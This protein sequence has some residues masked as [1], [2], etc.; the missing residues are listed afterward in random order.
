MN[1][2]VAPH[3]RH[4]LEACKFRL[5]SQKKKN[6]GMEVKICE[7]PTQMLSRRV[8]LLGVDEVLAPLNLKL[9]ISFRNLQFQ[10]GS[11]FVK[12]ACLQHGSLS[13][14]RTTR[15]GTKNHRDV[16]PEEILRGILN[17]I[18]IFYDHCSFL[19]FCNFKSSLTLMFVCSLTVHEHYEQ[20]I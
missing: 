13:W 18:M 5:F 11:K 19:F 10:W 20:N 1:C 6:I 14:V 15:D 8:D 4:S 16:L 17:I 2:F 9:Q 7:M 3:E 12:F